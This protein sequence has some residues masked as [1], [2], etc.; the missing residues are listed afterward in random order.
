[1][2]STS[3]PQSSCKCTE[4]DYYVNSF[5]IMV[6]MFLEHPMNLNSCGKY[7]QAYWKS[8]IHLIR[9]IESESSRSFTNQCCPK[10]RKHSLSPQNWF[11]YMQFQLNFFFLYNG[12][13]RRWC[14]FDVPKVFRD[15]KLPLHKQK[16]SK[17]LWQ[18]KF[19]NF[20]DFLSFP[21]T[22]ICQFR[23]YSWRAMSGGMVL[24]SSRGTP[25]CF[26]W[27]EKFQHQIIRSI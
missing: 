25:V 18:G 26:A 20:L 11:A 23:I 19:W 10:C 7:P 8:Q 4:K 21:P 2:M 13:S 5:V 27:Y 3:C 22:L 6:Y 15:R 16:L 17:K 12:E 1:M 24:K 9:R 14:R